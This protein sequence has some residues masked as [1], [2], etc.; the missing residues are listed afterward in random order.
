MLDVKFIDLQLNGCY[1][2]DFNSDDLSGEQLH[3]ACERL[4]ADSVAGILATIITDDRDR[5]SARLARLVRLRQQDPL[6]QRV[7]WGVHVEGPFIS[8]EPGYVGAHP[9]QHV[10]PAD[11]DAM[12]R[13]LDAAQGLV[14]L[15]T[16]APECDPGMKLTRFL[17]DRTIRVSAGHCDAS[18]DQLRAALDAG[19]SM[20]THLGNGCPAWLPRHD[21]VIQRVLSLADQLTICFIADGVHVP[22]PAL[23]NYL[24]IAGIERT[25][26]VTDGMAAAGL[27]AGRFSLGNQWVEVDAE[28]ATWS[29]DR[30][31]L[32]GS[33]ITMPRMAAKAQ[34]A[35]RLTS[36]EIAR[37][38]EENPRRLMVA[39]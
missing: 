7:I 2:V 33:A 15:V 10:R 5:M 31:H 29:A 27:G 32:V 35:L 26:F 30:S 23:G 6:A 24:R 37:L 39:K 19:L 17:S 34:G 22:Y 13:L 18:L 21:N 25:V 36:A 12:Q 14:R 20:F 1:G 16:L 28:G 4:Q 3:A 9:P 38:V 11:L 8:A